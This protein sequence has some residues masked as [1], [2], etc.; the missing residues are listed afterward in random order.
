MDNEKVT[1]NEFFDW[2]KIKFKEKEEEIEKLRGEFK[3][4]SISNLC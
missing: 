2:D 4:S 3:L 1:G